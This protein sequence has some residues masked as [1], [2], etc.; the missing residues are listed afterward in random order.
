MNFGIIGCNCVSHSVAL[1]LEVTDPHW[2]GLRLDPSAKIELNA[3][4]A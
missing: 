1:C 3:L 2:A 4:A